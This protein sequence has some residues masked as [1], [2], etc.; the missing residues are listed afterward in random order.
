MV[1]PS[2]R[3]N[4]SEKFLILEITAQKAEAIA[5][6]LDDKKNLEIREFWDNLTF[7]DF[8]RLAKSKS[9]LIVSI[10]RSLITS[11]F[12][13]LRWENELPSKKAITLIDLENFLFGEAGKVFKYCQSEAAEKLK[14]DYSDVI[15]IGGITRGF[16]V[17]GCKV[18]N[19]L[20]FP[21]KRLEVILELIFANRYIFEKWKKVLPNQSFFTESGRA[22]ISVLGRIKKT[23][24]NLLIFDLKESFLL[25]FDDKK[26]IAGVFSL[27]VLPWGINNLIQSIADCFGVSF[28][29]A[30]QI[31]DIYFRGE[32]SCKLLKKIN[33]IL[34]LS[35]SFLKKELKKRHL[36]G[37]IFVVRNFN[38]PFSLSNQKIFFK[39]LS[40][41]SLLEDFG[42]KIKLG[43]KLKNKK[44][45]WLKPLKFA[46]FLEFYYYQ[47]NLLPID[48]RLKRY[49]Y[50]LSQRDSVK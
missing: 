8:S 2:L 15:M 13:P 7:E 48:T 23:P 28:D 4:S 19:P 9:K 16:R 45:F 34:R 6:S 32:M 17:D 39:D 26:S 50:W 44:D 35:S 24:I 33:Q 49:L 11:V 22:A 30:W 3:F 43:K 29:V 25:G 21:A 20:G 10:D 1:F 31:Y 5:F 42:F 12:L 38:L 18:I 37:E 47:E 14:T 46:P 27:S 40:C 36:K 41:W